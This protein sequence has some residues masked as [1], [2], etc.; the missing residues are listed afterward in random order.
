MRYT[1]LGSYRHEA[2]SNLCDV[3]VKFVYVWGR[4]FTEGRGYTEG[5]NPKE[6]QDSTQVETLSPNGVQGGLAKLMKTNRSLF[7]RRKYPPTKLCDPL[8]FYFFPLL[9]QIEYM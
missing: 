5:T 8:T 3:T 1:Y 4:D 2:S 6:M 7:Y 9:M